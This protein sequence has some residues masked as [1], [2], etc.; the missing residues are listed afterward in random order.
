MSKKKSTERLA[1]PRISF[2]YN[3]GFETIDF[4]G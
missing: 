1:P 2:D 4:R 3:L